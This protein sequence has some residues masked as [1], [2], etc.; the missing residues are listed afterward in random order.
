MHLG[1]LVVK[2]AV[3]APLR[4]SMTVLTVAIMLTA[5]VFPRT[6]VDAQEQALHDAPVNRVITF[7]RRGWTQPLPRRYSEE[8][9]S[10]PGIT[11]AVG[12]VWAGFKLP[13]KDNV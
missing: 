7:P 10:L 9:R 5:F 12:V 4:T 3:R 8:V 1:Q 6:L 13:G 11:T 2:N